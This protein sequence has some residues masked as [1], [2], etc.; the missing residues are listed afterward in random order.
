MKN[1][2]KLEFM[3]LGIMDK[4]NLSWVLDIKIHLDVM[5]LEDTIKR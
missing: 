4:N 2:A 5:D 1:I 3:A